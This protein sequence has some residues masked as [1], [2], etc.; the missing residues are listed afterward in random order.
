MRPRDA[1]RRRPMW[2]SSDVGG[3]PPGRIESI[4]GDARLPRV[5]DRGSIPTISEYF[6]PRAAGA[7]RA[8]AVARTASIMDVTARPSRLAEQRFLMTT[9]TAY[10]SQGQLPHG[11]RTKSMHKNNKKL[12]SI[13]VASD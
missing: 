5:L 8:D 9:T 6:A 1:W 13:N 4:P 2:V 11:V 12:H 10:A 7:L 3:R